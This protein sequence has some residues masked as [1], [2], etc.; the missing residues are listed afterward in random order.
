MTKKPKSVEKTIEQ[1]D[2]DLKSQKKFP[3]DERFPITE[4]L[5]QTKQTKPIKDKKVLTQKTK[6]SKKIEQNPGAT[7]GNKKRRVYS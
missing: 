7:N 4:Q 5:K 2:Y 1:I 6:K 3:S